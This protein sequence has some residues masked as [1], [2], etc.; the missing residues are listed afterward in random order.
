MSLWVLLRNISS[1]SSAPLRV[2]RRISSGLSSPSTLRVLRCRHLFRF[3]G[4]L[5]GFNGSSLWGRLMAPLRVRPRISLGSTAF[6]WVRCLISA[7]LPTVLLQ[8]LQRISS[9]STAF[10]FGFTSAIF[11]FDDTSLRTVRRRIFWFDPAF[12]VSS[13]LFL[14]IDIAF[15]S[16]ST[17]HL[18]GLFDGVSSGLDFGLHCGLFRQKNITIRFK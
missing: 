9:G 7:G 17:V 8:V 16:S 2:R 3:D 11:E 1:G 12:S 15:S 4:T 5:F 13:A 18:F 10:F 6:S 14:E